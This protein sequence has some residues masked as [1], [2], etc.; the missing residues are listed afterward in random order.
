MHF[1][2]LSPETD[3]FILMDSEGLFEL[4]PFL[5]LFSYPVYEFTVKTYE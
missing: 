1:V 4:L 5:Q 3:V 2:L